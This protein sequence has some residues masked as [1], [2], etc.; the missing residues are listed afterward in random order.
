[1]LIHTFK[2]ATVACL[3]ILSVM[4][5]T[6]TGFATPISIGNSYSLINSTWTGAQAHQDTTDNV[7]WLVDNYGGPLPA[8]LTLPTD[9]TLYGKWGSGNWTGTDPA[10]TGDFSGDIGNWI[11]PTAWDTPLYYSVKAGSSN[12]NSG[13]GFEL[14]YANGL[15]FAD[16][17]T[18]GLS[19]HNLSHMSFWTADSPTSPGP[20]PVP[21]PTTMLLFGIGLLGLAGVVRRKK[22]H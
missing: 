19:N 9:L 7:N 8:G 14:W 11:A 21:E 15:T 1:M 20:N 5:L 17:D 16:W 2:K 6:D 12:G 3:L 18:K 13:G 22:L 4:L 10:F